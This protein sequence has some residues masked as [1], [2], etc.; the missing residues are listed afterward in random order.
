MNKK[1]VLVINPKSIN[2]MKAIYN[3]LVANLLDIIILGNRTNIYELCVKIHLNINLLQIV[4]CEN[5]NEIY[6]KLKKY[7]KIKN[8]SGIIVDGIN[9]EK[10]LNLYSYHSICNLIDFGVFKQSVFLIKNTVKI[11]FL[12][13]IR[14]TIQLI[15]CL[16]INNINVAIVGEREKALEK[17]RIIKQELGLK[18]VDIIDENKIIKCKYNIIVFEAKHKEIEYLEKINKLT[19]PRIIEIKKASNVY[20]FDANNKEFKNIF[21]QI[22]FLNKVNLLYDKINSQII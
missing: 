10:I 22:I 2:L 18:S 16:D 20:I 19:L 21:L 7:K 8:I 13:N 4:D 1:T 11:N 5:E 12:K 9:E 3:N 14:D 17:R 6:L 15:N